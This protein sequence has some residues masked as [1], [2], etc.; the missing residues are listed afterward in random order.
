MSEESR[1]EIHNEHG[2]RYHS[3]SICGVSRTLIDVAFSGL[4]DIV[5]RLDLGQHN[6]SKS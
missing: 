5:D 3:F 6:Y 1:R 4:Q 2:L